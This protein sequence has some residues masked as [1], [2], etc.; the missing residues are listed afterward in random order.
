M[1]HRKELLGACNGGSTK[2][3]LPWCPGTLLVPLP[4]PIN[5]EIQKK[6]KKRKIEAKASLENLAGIR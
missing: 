2:R 3:E 4:V 5:R 1:E 6:K